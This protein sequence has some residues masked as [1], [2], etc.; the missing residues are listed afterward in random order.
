MK[1]LVLRGVFVVLAVLLTV[2]GAAG[3][4]APAEMHITWRAHTYVPPTYAGKPLPTAGSRVTAS[5]F[6][7]QNGKFI[8]LVGKTIYWYLNDEF[9]EGGADQQTVEFRLPKD[10]NGTIADLMVRLPNTAG[11]LVNTIDIPIIAPQVAI[12]APFPRGVVAG[13]A[14]RVRAR[15][16]FFNT[17]SPAFLD[18]RWTVNGKEPPPEDP[19]NLSVAIEP[20]GAP[21]TSILVNLNL[22]NPVSFIEF[23][24]Q[25]K[26]LTLGQ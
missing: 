12:D 25:S 14:F 13:D 8:D 15:A 19:E 18:Y 4:S 20:G 5:V 26:T 9:I 22:R 2:R 17:P 7:T 11:G 1:R 16:Y 23:A 21:G 3:Q 6:V 24:G 10:K